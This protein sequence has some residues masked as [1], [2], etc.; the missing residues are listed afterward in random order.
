MA[1]LPPGV[2]TAPSTGSRPPADPT[3]ASLLDRIAGG[4]E[5]AFRDLFHR[6]HSALRAF[7]ASIAGEADADEAVQDVFVGLWHRRGALSADPSLR[8]YLFRAAR[9]RA[10]N[11]RRGR[12]RWALR[13][14]G[15]DAA[16]TVAAPPSGGG[17]VSQAVAEAVARLPERQRMAFQLRHSHGLSYAEIASAMAV[18]PKTVENHLARA[19]RTLRYALSPELAHP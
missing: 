14:S 18:T 12:R 5:T 15:L 9:S 11:V 10:L 2:C 3:D 13:F 6:Y 19:L 8:A 16:E 1:S 7:A 17:E 4:D